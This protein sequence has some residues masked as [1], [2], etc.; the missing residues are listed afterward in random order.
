MHPLPT[1]SQLPT[2]P[3]PCAGVPANPW[4]TASAAAKHKKTKKH[5]QHKKARKLSRP[6]RVAAGFTG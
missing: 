3:N 5:R 1:T 6:P 2:M 4:C